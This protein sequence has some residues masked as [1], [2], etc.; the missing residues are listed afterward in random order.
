MTKVCPRCGEEYDNAIAFCAKD[1]TR[2][3]SRGLQ[4]DLVGTVVADRYRIVSRIGEG[5]MGQVYL[6]EHVRMKRKSAIKIMRP[7]LVHDVEA[8]QRFTR[9]AENASQITHPNVAAIFDFGETADGIVY[10]AMEYVDGASLA[11]KLGGEHV[12]HP[13]VGAD[14]LGQ[15]A[16][17]LQTAHD[18]GILH[19]D[20]K[21]DNIML[22][23]RNDG[24]F[25]V[26]LVDFG[27]ARTMDGA[28]QKVTRTGF[29]IGTPAFM[30]PEQLAGDSLDARSDQYSLALVAFVTLTGKDA[31]PPES[32]KES[33]IARLT[34]R[35][36]TLQ[37]AREDVRW[38]QELQ[39]VFDRALSPEPG[40]RFPTINEFARALA[41]AISGMTPTQTAELYRRALD[42][43][44]A[45]VAMRTP[46]SDLQAYRTPAVAQSTI[47]P[48][49]RPTVEREGEDRR[50]APRD[51][52]SEDR[53]GAARS[54]SPAP[55]VRFD[56]IPASLVSGAYPKFGES[57]VPAKDEDV[58]PERAA[59]SED[60]PESATHGID[61]PN[62][63]YSARTVYDASSAS[64]VG[65]DDTRGE[66]V[67]EVSA[68]AE[69]VLGTDEG[70]ES[71]GNGPVPD[72]GIA[73]GFQSVTASADATV[74]GTSHGRRAGSRNVL[75]G[76]GAAVV[77][78]GVWFATRGTDPAL[79]VTDTMAAV[80]GPPIT[81]TST[82]V[83]V[84]T[85]GTSS[86]TSAGAERATSDSVK[87]I[88]SL[89][90]VADSTKRRNALAGSF[91]LAE[92]NA[93][94]TSNLDFRSTSVS[95]DDIRVVIMSPLTTAWR[96]H[97]DSVYKKNNPRQRGE[98]TDS[99]DYVDPILVWRSWKSA[100]ATRKPAYIVQVG[101]SGAPTELEPTKLF[102][103]KRGDVTSFVL[104]RDDAPV[105]LASGESIDALFF[106]TEHPE[107]KHPN[108]QMTV[109]MVGP[110][111]FAPNA[112]GSW[113]KFEVRA[114]DRARNGEIV[115]VSIP[116]RLVVRLHDELASWR[117]MVGS[118][119]TP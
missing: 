16:D 77:V 110:E 80:N 13:D 7:A 67:R 63:P 2:L 25:M 106:A 100:L 69:S 85:G 43:R 34:S 81:D 45:H 97:R 84:P 74:R 18:L 32:S 54:G 79:P 35:P 52:D 114:S 10:L 14:I 56:P 6:A 65:Y 19:R 42:I 51:G 73:S 92:W 59:A 46:H 22:A 83:A 116:Q 21:P 9:E 23:R 94:A 15:A 49:S 90:R 28:D 72:G 68:N 87:R 31:F 39:D 119:N 17:A 57:A 66:G 61:V 40:D 11:A 37:E 38:P 102:D 82:S 44:L 108:P 55:P 50:A 8:L 48:P 1:G 103:I 113:P 115:R 53:R 104:L 36:R 41:T 86:G 12:L 98:F 20:L 93:A 96:S 24:T 107:Q 95:K 33:L 71:G 109:A 27:I 64:R 99:Y 112:D 30:S 117:A 3:V 70:R 60:R 26:K 101:P 88:D 58:D 29:A 91:P 78:A 47:T 105:A 118:A 4:S 76:V 5:G 75:I 111:T 89:K 62:A